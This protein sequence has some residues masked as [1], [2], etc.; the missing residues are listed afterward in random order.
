MPVAVFERDESCAS[1]ASDGLA[2]GCAAFSEQVAEALSTAGFLVT[3]REALPS[4]VL[5]AM[6]AGEALAMPGLVLVGYSATLD[7]LQLI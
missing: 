4:E 6:C 1:D 3:G 2:A 7:C 5:V